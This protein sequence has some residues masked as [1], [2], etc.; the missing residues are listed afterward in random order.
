MHVNFGV[1]GGEKKRKEVERSG[2]IRVGR[3]QSKQGSE[4]HIRL[5][6]HLCAEAGLVAW[7]VCVSFE[8]TSLLYLPCECGWVFK[9]ILS[10]QPSCARTD[11][12][13]SRWAPG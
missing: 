3:L 5:G 6:A 7:Y 12:C 1:W 9:N 11:M 2:A 13:L 8:H 10:H 4:V